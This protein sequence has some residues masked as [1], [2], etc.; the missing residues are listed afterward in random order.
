MDINLHIKFPDQVLTLF[1]TLTR[2]LEQQGPTD[3]APPTARKEPEKSSKPVSE[4][5]DTKT[6]SEP[7]ETKDTKPDSKPDAKLDS[8]QEGAEQASKPLSNEEK[9]TKIRTLV[10]KLA[11]SHKD[12]LSALMKE[13]GIAKFSETQQDQLDFVIEKLESYAK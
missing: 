7:G 5:K 12:E 2:A 13:L 3:A 10:V 6:A 1:Q 11:K 8:K 4:K 9:L